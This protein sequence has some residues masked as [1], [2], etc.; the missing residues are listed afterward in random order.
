MRD[1]LDRQVETMLDKGIIEPSASCWN[2][3]KILIQKGSLD[4][5]LLC[6]L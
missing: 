2:F 4:G 6:G 1:E 5:S 3:P